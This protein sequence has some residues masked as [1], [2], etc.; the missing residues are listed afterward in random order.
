VSRLRRNDAAGFT[1][2]ELLVV[3]II[4]GILAAIAIPSFLNQRRAGFNAQAVS[5]L[6]NLVPQQLGLEAAGEPFSIDPNDFDEWEATDGTIVCA[7]VDSGDLSL[8]S[9]HPEG[10]VVYTWTSVTGQLGAVDSLPADDLCVNQI[11]GSTE[12][13]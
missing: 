8:A 7:R 2:I 9:W 6:R 3:V 10:S 11:A 13:S 1:L 4:I 12:I 5:D